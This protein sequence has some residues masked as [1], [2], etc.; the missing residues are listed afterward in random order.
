MEFLYALDY[1]HWILLGLVLLVLE[2]FVGGAFLMWMGF[3]SIVVGVLVL[4]F[5][6]V[7][8]HPSWQWQ[9]VLFAIGSFAAIILWR[10]YVND[11]TASDA[12]DLNHR[13]REYIGRTVQLKAAIEGGVGFINIDDTRWR[14]NGPDLPVGTRVKIISM[15]D[16]VFTVQAADS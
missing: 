2:I 12:P 6:W 5:P 1:Y 16:M 9:L 7:G 8:I 14:V 15:Q 4:I 10:R 13:G 11:D 3:S